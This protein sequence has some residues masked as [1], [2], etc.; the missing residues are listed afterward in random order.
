MLG[1]AEEIVSAI[2]KN[3]AELERIGNL[4]KQLAEVLSR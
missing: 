4:I 3:T 2:E 1:S